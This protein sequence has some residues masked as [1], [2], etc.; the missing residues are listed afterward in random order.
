M[1]GAPRMTMR[2]SSQHA[3]DYFAQSLPGQVV[4]IVRI[5]DNRLAARQRL[6]CFAFSQRAVANCKLHNFSDQ[7]PSSKVRLPYPKER[8]VYRVMS[9]RI[10]ALHESYWDVL[11][12]ILPRRSF[13]SRVSDLPAGMGPRLNAWP[14]FDV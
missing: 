3:T 8:G 1:I 10:L 14:H 12:V 6:R 2:I 13:S 4:H 11:N 9:R 7:T 5:A